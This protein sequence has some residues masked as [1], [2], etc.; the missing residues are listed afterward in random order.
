M[1]A[2]RRQILAVRTVEMNAHRHLVVGPL[3]HHAHVDQPVRR[4]HPGD[5]VRR[6]AVFKLREIIDDRFVTVDA[7]VQPGLR[8]RAVLDD[9]IPLRDGRLHVRFLTQ[10]A[11]AVI[12]KRGAGRD[13]IAKVDSQVLVLV[14]RVELDALRQS[15]SQFAA[16]ARPQR[17]LIQVRQ[18]DSVDG[19]PLVARLQN[20]AANRLVGM[21]VLQCI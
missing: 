5:G 20:Q 10:P 3:L 1:A 14:N 12:I 21:W 2:A 18:A 6:L 16:H 4:R 15:Q 13:D 8:M 7:D 19:R 9:Q 11:A 17:M